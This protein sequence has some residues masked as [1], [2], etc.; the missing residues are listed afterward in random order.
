MQKIQKGKSGSSQEQPEIC[1]GKLKYF[2]SL[3]FLKGILIPKE[4]DGN[5]LTLFEDLTTATE[6]DNEVSKA[7]V[8]DTGLT[9]VET[10]SF[11]N[12]SPVR[13]KSEM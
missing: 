9:S 2:K 13:P 10:R 4:I 6:A 11:T 7:E 8:N 12:A 1:S 5:L 3:L